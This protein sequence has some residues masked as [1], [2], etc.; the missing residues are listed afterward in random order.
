MRIEIYGPVTLYRIGHRSEQILADKILDR[1]NRIVRV[2]CTLLAIRGF[3][4]CRDHRFF[5][6]RR[7]FRNHPAS[8]ARFS[9]TAGA[10][11]QVG[12]ITPEVLT[13][14]GRVAACRPGLSNMGESRMF[15]DRS[16]DTGCGGSPKGRPR[17][18]F[19]PA[20]GSPRPP[21][22]EISGR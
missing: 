5:L 20:A 15:A 8:A 18:S 6:F 3:P 7:F 17:D 10:K 19:S 21:A 14:C 1:A 13:G 12:R 2:F 16:A 4:F 22:R 9:Y 11:R